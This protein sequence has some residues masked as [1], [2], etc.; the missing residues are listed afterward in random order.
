MKKLSI[1]AAAALAFA[2]AAPAVAQEN[3]AADPFVATQGT[4]E[5]AVIGGVTLLVLIAAASN[6]G[7]SGSD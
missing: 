2:S 5:L 3:V 1:A 7:S 6:D 4:T